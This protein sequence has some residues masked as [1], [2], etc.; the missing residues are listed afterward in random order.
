MITPHAL[1]K[2]DAANICRDRAALTAIEPAI[3]TEH[4]RVRHGMRV[5]HSETGQQ[6][7]RVG[8]RNVVSIFI[9]IEKQIWN[10]QHEN[11]P[12]TKSESAGE[13]QSADKIFGFLSVPIFV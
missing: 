3:R 7:F 12:M 13:I 9:W 6:N 4:K 2:F 8:I 11:S 5:F 10:L 1:L